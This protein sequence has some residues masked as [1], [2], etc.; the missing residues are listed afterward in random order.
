MS[1]LKP[2]GWIM[3][4]AGWWIADDCHYGDA[5]V[6]RERDGWYAYTPD[7]EDGPFRTM[8]EAMAWAADL[9]FIKAATRVSE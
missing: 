1:H 8:R 2:K 9:A 3:H 7:R 6:C 5:A 4:E